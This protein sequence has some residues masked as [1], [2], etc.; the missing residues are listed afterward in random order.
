MTNNIAYGFTI[1][2]DNQNATDA[3]GVEHSNE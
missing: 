2:I 3:V 1:G